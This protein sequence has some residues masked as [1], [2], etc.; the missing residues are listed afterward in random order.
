MCSFGINATNSN[1]CLTFLTTLPIV[2]VVPK[3]LKRDAEQRVREA[4]GNVGT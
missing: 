2:L 1:E 3:P 4:P